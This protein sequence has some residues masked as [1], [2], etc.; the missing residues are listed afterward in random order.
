MD[1]LLRTKL[2]TP[3]LRSS[4]VPR[5]RLIAKL[6]AGLG[7]KLTLV[8]APAGFG[9][10]TLIVA[11]LATLRNAQPSRPAAWLSLDAGDND[12]VRWLAYLITALQMVLP[13]VG[14]DV[15][16]VLQTPSGAPGGPPLEPLLTTLLNELAVAAAPF[17]LAL[18]DYHVIERSA[19]DD[20]LAFL[21]DHAP[22]TIHLVISTRADPSLP[23]PR[24]RARG[25]LVE[26]RA[27]DLRFT[28]DEAATFLNEVMRIDLSPADVA[29]L[30]ARTEGWIAGLQLAAL[31]LQGADNVS[32]LIHAFRGSNRY[33]LDYLADEVLYRQPPEAKQFLLYTSILDRFSAELCDAVLGEGRSAAEDSSA[34]T[35]PLP[36]AHLQSQELLEHFEHTNLF[37]IPLDSERRWYRYHQL[38]TDLLRDRLQRAQPELAP[39]LHRRAAQ[40]YQQHGFTAD[41]IRH[42]L[43]A[44]AFDS[45]GELIEQ[46][47]RSLLARGEHHTIYGWIDALPP[48]LVRARP[49]LCLAHAL[50]LASSRDVRGIAARLQDVEA[51]LG[52]AAAGLTETDARS[53]AGEI[54]AYRALLIFWRNEDITEAIGLCQQALAQLPPDDHYLRGVVSRYSLSPSW[55]IQHLT[56]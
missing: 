40:W 29:I 46:A 30:E 10:T 32:T 19:I 14:A 7:A 31:S 47:A 36:T 44:Q 5:P 33:I 24:W 12:P 1:T 41:A 49:R 38:F 6:D 35:A 48:D 42:L 11:W 3:T 43:A 4:F 55:I 56:R 23:L 45:A 26:I 18:D 34:R 28:A 53:L 13:G 21:I 9:K 8:S 51:V 37:L 27:R 54:A 22:P 20:A 52:Q 17:I 2:Y 16:R 25:E 39:T 15:L 50:A